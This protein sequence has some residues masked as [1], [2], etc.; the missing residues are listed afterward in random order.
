MMDLCFAN[1]AMAGTRLSC[2]RHIL[3]RRHFS[4]ATANRAAAMVEGGVGITTRYGGGAFIIAL[5]TLSLFLD[6]RIQT[7][8][9]P[10]IRPL[11]KESIE[12]N[13][14]FQH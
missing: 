13:H 10:S 11:K 4:V 2:D 3:A 6:R 14:G 5:S 9:I 1:L 8:S 7:L 12:E